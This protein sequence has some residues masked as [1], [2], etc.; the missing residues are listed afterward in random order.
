MPPD[1]DTFDYKWGPQ[2]LKM[3]LFTISKSRDGLAAAQRRNC[4]P[5][6]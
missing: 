6:S 3:K 2:T 5:V 1:I 4:A